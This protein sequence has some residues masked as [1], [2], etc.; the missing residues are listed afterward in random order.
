[1]EPFIYK[2]LNLLTLY[3]KG[4]MKGRNMHELEYKKHTIVNQLHRLCAH[5]ATGSQKPHRCPVQ[6]IAKQVAAIKGIPLIVNNEFK[7]VVC[8]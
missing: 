3:I 7:G 5:C 1:L 2:Y 4:W 6:L 8:M